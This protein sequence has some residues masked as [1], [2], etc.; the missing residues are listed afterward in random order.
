VAFLE[1]AVNVGLLSV[2]Y[3]SAGIFFAAVSQKMPVILLIT[4]I[5]PKCCYFSWHFFKR[6]INVD[7]YW[8]LVK[9]PAIPAFPTLQKKLKGLNVKFEPTNCIIF[10]SRTYC[11]ISRPRFPNA[12]P[13][14]LADVQS[15]AG[16]IRRRL[17]ALS[18][19]LLGAFHWIPTRTPPFRP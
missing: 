5:L 10:L 16:R 3:Q 12:P 19:L 11:S 13:P 15:N 1:S 7:V 4:G 9:A 2:F 6:A 17:H 18:E 14:P 8:H